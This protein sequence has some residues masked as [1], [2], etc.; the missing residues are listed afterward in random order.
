MNESTLLFHLMLSK[1]SLSGYGRNLFQGTLELDMSCSQHLLGPWDL[2]TL[3]FET[4]A[5]KIY[6]S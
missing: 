2:G 4:G 1:T 5:D 6:T 3:N